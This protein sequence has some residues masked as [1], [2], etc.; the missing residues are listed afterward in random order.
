MIV[1]YELDNHENKEVKAW[2]NFEI[3][4]KNRE[5]TKVQLMLVEGN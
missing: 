5:A 3:P 4:K 2:I 1:C